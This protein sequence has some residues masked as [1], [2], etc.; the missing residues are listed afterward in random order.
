MIRDDVLDLLHGHD[1]VVLLEEVLEDFS[2]ERQIDL[3]VRHRRERQQA[4][5]RAF[6]LADVG[7]DV[8]RDELQ[9]LVRDMKRIILCAFA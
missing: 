3:A 9:D 8:G 5:E 1:A 4:D 6:Q 2:C 7:P